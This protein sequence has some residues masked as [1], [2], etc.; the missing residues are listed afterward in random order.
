[1]VC[2]LAP[3]GYLIMADA[4]LLLIYVPIAILGFY[5]SYKLPFSDS[6]V[7]V[8]IRNTA[9]KTSK[10]LRNSN[11]LHRIPCVADWTDAAA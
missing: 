8:T 4:T 11:C 5:Y 9:K 7:H 2:L 10:R 1:M 6:V 3:M